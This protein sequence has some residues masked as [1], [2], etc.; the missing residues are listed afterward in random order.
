MEDRF[1]HF[2]YALFELSR[3]W[4]KITGSEMKRYE[5]SGTHGYYLITLFRYPEGLT[6]ANFCEILGRDKAGVSRALRLLEERGLVHKEGTN[7]R[8]Y[9]GVYKLTE[10]GRKA[11][12]HTRRRVSTAVRHTGTK[13]TEEERR[14]FYSALEQITADLRFLSENGLPAEEGE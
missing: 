2:S 3:C 10:D 5:L 4:Y 13:L 7:R 12:E 9:N 1:E 6:A 14:I 8:N 11:A